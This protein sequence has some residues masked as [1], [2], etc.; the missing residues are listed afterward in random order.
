M[1]WAKDCFSKNFILA[2]NEIT[3]R[4]PSFCIEFENILK[5]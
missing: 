1:T 2:Q 4:E 5:F 3:K